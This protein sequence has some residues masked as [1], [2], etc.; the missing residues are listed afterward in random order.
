MD[1]MLGIDTLPFK[2]TVQMMAAIAK[3]AVRASS[4][5]RAT[6][7]V[8]EHYGIGISERTVREVTDFVG[9]VVFEHC[10]S[11]AEKAK[12]ALSDPI[13][14]R[15][16]HKRPDD[17][18]YLEMDGA[19]VDTRPE[20]EG[21]NNWRECK[22]GIGFLSEDIKS[23]ITHKGEERRAITKKRL[24]GYIGY[25]KD[26]QYF[27]LSVAE[28]YQYKYRS[29]IVII[30]DGAEWIHSIQ[31]EL[32]PDAIHILDLSHVK[33]HVNRYAKWLFSD[34]A[35]RMK[36]V[37]RVNTLIEDSKIEKVLK[38]LCKYKDLPHPKE[39]TN[40]YNYIKDRAESMDY[41][42]YI[43]AGY[44]I[45]S[46]ASESANKYTMQD[47]MKLQG[48]RWNVPNAQTMLTLKTYYEAE[49]WSEIELLIQQHCSARDFSI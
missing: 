37:N 45:G 7:A 34:D 23:W 29:K 15:K 19:M 18:L 36:W 4:Y 49:R 40:L 38:L 13:D 33:E 14:R 31:Q 10:K 30:S 22:I 11:E 2:I 43:E 28:Q 47:R 46:G 20:S 1:V 24:T 8:I 12:S 26:F 25:Y 35:D 5:R 16:K 42:A 27:L 9:A 32:F 21:D 17:I 48:M 41:K 6:E 44:F 39:V 3:E